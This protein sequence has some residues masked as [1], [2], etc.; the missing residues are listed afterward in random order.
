VETEPC[1]LA[2]EAGKVRG[3]LPLHRLAGTVG[4]NGSALLHTEAR[5]RRAGFPDG[6]HRKLSAFSF[7]VHKQMLA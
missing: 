4:A 3:I 5:Q 7:R 6:F 1:G 2:R